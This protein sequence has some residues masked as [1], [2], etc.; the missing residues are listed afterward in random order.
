[1]KPLVIRRDQQAGRRGATGGYH[2]WPKK[3][4]A[5]DDDEEEEEALNEAS[6]KMVYI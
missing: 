5:R 4:D 1:M 2:V 6:R 3:K